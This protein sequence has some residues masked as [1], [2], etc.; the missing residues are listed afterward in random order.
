[1]SV[2]HTVDFVVKWQ[3]NYHQKNKK[4]FHVKELGRHRFGFAVNI[5]TWSKT[6]NDPIPYACKIHFVDP[7]RTLP[8]SLKLSPVTKLAA[9]LHEVYFIDATNPSYNNFRIETPAKPMP[10]FLPKTFSIGRNLLWALR[11]KVDVSHIEF[12]VSSHV[13]RTIA[14]SAYFRKSSWSFAI[15]VYK[16]KMF[17]GDGKMKENDKYWLRGYDQPDFRF[18]KE[19]YDP[20]AFSADSRDKQDGLLATDYFIEFPEGFSRNRKSLGYG[21]VFDIIMKNG[22]SD[23]LTF[24]GDDMSF[25]E[26]RCAKYLKLGNTT[27][28]TCTRISCQEPNGEIDTQENYVEIKSKF[29]MSEEKFAKYESLKLW[30]VDTL[31]LSWC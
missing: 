24:I 26:V 25:G 20:A 18:H 15:I 14:L 8:L 6:S 31:C 21:R 23:P 30:T 17:I 13:L 5:E 2:K 16:N 4:I 11:E 7:P 1:M 12:F 22:A 9:Y 29:K 28:L 19:V 10:E 3:R 27:L